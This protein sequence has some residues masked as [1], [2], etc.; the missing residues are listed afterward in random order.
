LHALVLGAGVEYAVNDME[1]V[2]LRLDYRFV[3]P[4]DVSGYKSDAFDQHHLMVGVA[5]TF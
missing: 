3:K 1:N 4:E 2:K 5:Y